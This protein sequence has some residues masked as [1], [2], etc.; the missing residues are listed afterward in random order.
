MAIPVYPHSGR[1]CHYWKLRKEGFRELH[2]AKRWHL[3]GAYAEKDIRGVTIM[4]TIVKEGDDH[5]LVRFQRKNDF[6][7]VITAEFKESGA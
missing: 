6:W 5:I 1:K 2:L 3:K 4:E 7:A